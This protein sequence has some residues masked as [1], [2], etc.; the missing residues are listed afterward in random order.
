MV[1]ELDGKD[2]ITLKAVYNG[3]PRPGQYMVTGHQSTPRIG[4]VAS[5]RGWVVEWTDPPGTKLTK[6]P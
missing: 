4:G 6:A 3:Q 1:L 2:T 5:P